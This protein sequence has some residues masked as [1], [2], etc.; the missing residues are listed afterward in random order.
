MSERRP[1]SYAFDVGQQGHIVDEGGR[2]GEEAKIQR[3]VISDRPIISIAGM[4]LTL[5]I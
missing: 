5:I 4:R 3:L 2:K 1:C